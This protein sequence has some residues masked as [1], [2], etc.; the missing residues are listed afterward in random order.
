M[1]VV[2]PGPG[3]PAEGPGPPAEG[4]GA[5]RRGARGRPSREGHR[6]PPPP[7]G[8]GRGGWRPQRV[9]DKLIKYKEKTEMRETTRN[10]NQTGNLFTKV[11][12]TPKTQNDPM[13]DTHLL[14][15]GFRKKQG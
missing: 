9:P 15:V 5:A 7:W 14:V 4:P 10:R 2:G 3:P 11:E 13:V 1:R 12:I 8:P 6:R